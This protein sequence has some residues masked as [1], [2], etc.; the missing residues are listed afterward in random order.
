MSKEN[1][2]L[3][4]QVTSEEAKNFAEKHKLTYFETSAK[5]GLNMNLVFEACAHDV[6][7]KIK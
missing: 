7:G 3:R 5:N 1:F 6:F 2:N 4:R